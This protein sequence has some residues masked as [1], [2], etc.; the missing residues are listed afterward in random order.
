MDEVALT[1]QER[2][3][4]QNRMLKAA[5]RRLVKEVDIYQRFACV[6]WANSQ[7]YMQNSAQSL[8]Q[9]VITGQCDW[10]QNRKE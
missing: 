3:E 8:A 2:I 4:L 5:Q 7:A 6:A 1:D 9:A 10:D